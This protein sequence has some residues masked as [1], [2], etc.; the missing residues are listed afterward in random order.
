MLSVGGVGELLAQFADKDINDFDFRLIH[1]A[2]EM[3]KKHF[4]C[5]RHAFA[6]TEK[7]KDLI[8]LAGQMDWRAVGFDGFSFKV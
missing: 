3:I 1:A 7:F 2:I 6:Q 8:F 5:Q 4:F